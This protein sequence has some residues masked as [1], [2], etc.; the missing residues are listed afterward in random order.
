[1]TIEGNKK[2]AEILIDLITQQLADR[3]RVAHTPT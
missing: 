1:M 2:V 3:G